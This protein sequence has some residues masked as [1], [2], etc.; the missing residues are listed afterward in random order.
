MSQGKTCFCLVYFRLQHSPTDKCEKGE[1]Q[2][3]V[4]FELMYSLIKLRANLLWF[5]CVL[6]Y[7]SSQLPPTMIREYSCEE[8]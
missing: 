8:A 7:Y 1:A 4:Q 6:E 3:F 5:W 2:H